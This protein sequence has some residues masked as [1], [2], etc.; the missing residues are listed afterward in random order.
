MNDPIVL[1]LIAIAITATALFIGLTVHAHIKTLNSRLDGY[2]KA[3]ADVY[4]DGG[5][6]DRL[7][8]ERDEYKHLSALYLELWD[9]AEAEVEEQDQMLELAEAVIDASIMVIDLYIAE[10]PTDDKNWERRP[11]PDNADLTKL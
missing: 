7:V 1:T 5:E 10:K 2:K 4:A 3:L 9:A 8:I 11:V 6:I